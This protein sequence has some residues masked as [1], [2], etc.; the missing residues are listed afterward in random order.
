MENETLDM[1]SFIAAY[2][3]PLQGH[4]RSCAADFIVDEQMDVELSGTGEHLWLLV[5]KTGANTDW[6][7]KQLAQAA[8]VPAKYVGYAGLKDR[9]AVTTQ[10]FSLHLAG[11]DDPDFSSLPAEIEILQQQ[12]HDRKLQ[13]GT[14]T[15]NHFTLTL[16]ECQGDVAAAQAICE[17]IK[18]HGIPNYYG[19]QRFGHNFGNVHKAR[20]WFQGTF[21]PKQRSQRSLYLSAARSWLFNQ[22]LAG[23]VRQGNWNQR[24]EGDVFIFNGSNAWFA[25]DASPELA[26][27]LATQ[28]IH[29]SGVLWGR[30]ELASQQ[31][32]AALERHE[33]E[34]LPVLC[35]GLEKQ[36]LKQER[37]ALRTKIDALELQVV[38]E[39]TLQLRF[40]LPVGAYA[41][42]LLAQLGDF[43]IPASK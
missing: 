31:A 22:V 26:Q 41:T 13:R 12:R 42:V 40:Q 36:G 14:L 10:W 39:Q 30:G 3:A 8:D 9:H 1:S 38:D 28:E 20:Y 37:R 16:R 6:V 34:Q 32:M 27:R 11:K 17:Q 7:A 29:P 15:G 4:Y 23:R 5:R 33:A 21:K 43:T 25:D 18:Q 2:S 24:L 35:A 19:V